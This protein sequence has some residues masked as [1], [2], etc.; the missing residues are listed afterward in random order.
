MAGYHVSSLKP[1]EVATN[2]RLGT[3]A[4]KWPE[5]TN[6]PVVIETLLRNA[7]VRS[8]DSLH[9]RLPSLLIY[10]SIPRVSI[11]FA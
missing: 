11:C 4:L 10:P 6:K 5:E 3:F 1:N 8:I 7:S 9:R 2:L